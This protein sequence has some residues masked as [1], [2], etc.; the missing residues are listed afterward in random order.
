MQSLP[1]SPHPPRLGSD[2]FIVDQHAADEKTNFERLSRT[3][4]LHRQPLLLP[5]PLPGLTPL[6]ASVIR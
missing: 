4:V 6:D 2:L 3:L 5:R 1:S